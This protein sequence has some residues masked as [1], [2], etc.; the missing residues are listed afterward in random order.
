MFPFLFPLT[1]D[2]GGFLMGCRKQGTLPEPR[3][4]RRGQL[5][6]RVNGREFVLGQPESRQANE[7]YKAILAAWGAGGGRLP[8]GFQN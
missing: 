7:R 6:L 4:N 1:K 5:R 8:D 3:L 2:S